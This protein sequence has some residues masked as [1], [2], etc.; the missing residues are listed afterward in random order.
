MRKDMITFSKVVTELLSA[1]HHNLVQSPSEIR[2]QAKG[3]EDDPVF[4]T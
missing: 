3:V 2:Q 4:P 1:T